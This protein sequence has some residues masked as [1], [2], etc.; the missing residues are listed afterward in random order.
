M[1]FEGW[2]LRAPAHVLNEE[3][4]SQKKS[5]WIDL[6]LNFKGDSILF[7]FVIDCLSLNY[8]HTG[9]LGSQTN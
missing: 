2:K 4:L 8:I 3:N 6:Y 7:L 9:V 5:K 1:H